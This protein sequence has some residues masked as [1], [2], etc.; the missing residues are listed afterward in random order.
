MKIEHVL[1]FFSK[2][3]IRVIIF[4]V[5]TRSVFR[6]NKNR[7]LKNGSCE[8]AFNSSNYFLGINYCQLSKSLQR[9]SSHQQLE[10]FLRKLF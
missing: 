9:H 3:R 7:I 6:T 5:F 8:R 1:C 4:N 2:L 10:T